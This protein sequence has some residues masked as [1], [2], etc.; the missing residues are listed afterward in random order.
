MEKVKANYSENKCEKWPVM[1]NSKCLCTMIYYLT[2]NI[3]AVYTRQFFQ[4]WSLHISQESHSF[5]CI[6][7]VISLPKLFNG[8]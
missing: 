5:N 3:S 6:Q 4:N 2:V 1:R 7:D 8:R